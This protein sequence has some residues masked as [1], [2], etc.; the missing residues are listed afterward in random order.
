MRQRGKTYPTAVPRKKRHRQSVAKVG[1]K[2]A[3]I[4]KT[5]V[6]KSVELKGSARPRRSDTTPHP[7]APIIIYHQPV[8]FL[9][10]GKELTPAIVDAERR[11]TT[12]AERSQWT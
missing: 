7:T 1:A 11:P 5:A 2:L 12:R 4:P 9:S 8:L 10:G 3:A 6:R